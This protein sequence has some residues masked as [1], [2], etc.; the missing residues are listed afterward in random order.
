MDLKLMTLTNKLIAGSNMKKPTIVMLKKG[1]KV[2]PGN[3]VVRDDG[4]IVVEESKGCCGMRVRGQKSEDMP[5]G[6]YFRVVW[7]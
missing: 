5:E 1:S 7:K 2:K 4:V 6:Y 3:I